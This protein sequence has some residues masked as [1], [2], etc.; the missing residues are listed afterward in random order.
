MI[1]LGWGGGGEEGIG[2]PRLKSDILSSALNH[3]DPG[4]K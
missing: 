1:L 3:G 2:G 4:S